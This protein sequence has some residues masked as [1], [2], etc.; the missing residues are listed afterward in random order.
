LLPSPHRIEE[1]EKLLNALPH[2]RAIL[3]GNEARFFS[4]SEDRMTTGHWTT[5]LEQLRHRLFPRAVAETPDGQLLDSFVTQGD[6]VAFEALVRRH[7]PMVLGVCQRVLRQAEDAE[8]AFQAAFL[9]LARKAGSVR[10]REQ[11]GNWLY[12]VAYRTALKSRTAA[13]RRRA[14]ERQV[15]LM[16]EEAVPPVRVECDWQPLL[17]QEL[18]R[19]PARFRAAVVLCDLEGKSRKEVAQELGVPEGTLSA[20]LARARRLLAKRLTRQGVVLAAGG[21]AVLFAENAAPAAVPSSLVISTVQAAAFGAAGEAAAAGVIS[22]QVATLT[23]GV[24]RAM[25]LSKLQLAIVALFV[26]A[27]AG[28]GLGFLTHQALADKPAADANPVKKPEA[29]PNAK[30]VKKPEADAP[31]LGGIIKAV[32]LKQKTLTLAIPN[33]EKKETTDRTF[34][35]AADFKVLLASDKKEAPAAG[36]LDDLSEGA[37]AHLKLSAD[38]KTV[39]EAVLQA[40]SLRGVVKAIDPAKNTLTVL[41]GDKKQAAEQTLTLA[42]DVKVQL[43]AD[44]KEKEAPPEGKLADVKEGSPVVLKLSFDKKTVRS[45]AV[46]GKSIQGGVKKVDA[47]NNTITI[48]VKED[49][50][51]VEKTFTLAADASIFVP[52][53]KKGE[54]AKL[55]DLTEGAGVSLKLALDGKTVVVVS[56][57]GSNV[58]GTLKGVDVGGNTITVT[59]K[60]DGGPADKTYELAKDVRVNLDG[61]KEAGQLTDLTMGNKVAL[62]LSLDRKRVLSVRKAKE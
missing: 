60:E 61:Q 4:V 59:V 15:R 26:V 10:P 14:R 16:T 31:L 57:T 13:A 27:V 8:D 36:K 41:A 52:E 47:T 48:E 42:P 30:P 33:K 20:H 5:A 17:D 43:P 9:V 53:G 12:G 50:Q 3:R 32:D 19:L 55:A 49:G 51:A 37:S 34:T 18:H 29:D 45:I 1:N 56:T 6:Q 7:G 24:L 2:P 28:G 22:G 39:V 35:F 62:Q 21:V 25:F 44:K 38:Q 46:E 58:G 23:E 40:P 11:V 54:E